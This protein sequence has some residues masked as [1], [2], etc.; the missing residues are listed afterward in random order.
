MAAG[1][2]AKDTTEIEFTKSTLVQDTE[3][4]ER[5]IATNRMSLKHLRSHQTTTQLLVFR[6]GTHQSAWTELARRSMALLVVRE[7]AIALR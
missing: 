7:N 1:K 6:C 5:K 4:R 2:A 3:V